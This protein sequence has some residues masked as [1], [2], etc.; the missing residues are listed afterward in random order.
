M[1]LQSGDSDSRAVRS[2]ASRMNSRVVGFL[3]GTVMA[4]A[5]GVALGRSLI[6]DYNGSYEFGGPD[7]RGD[8]VLLTF[9]LATGGGYLVAGLVTHLSATHR[10]GQGMLIGLTLMLPVAGA[11]AVWWFFSQL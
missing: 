1:T 7:S 5:C 6:D 4:A 10:L 11:V 2:M 3:V 9:I 8:G